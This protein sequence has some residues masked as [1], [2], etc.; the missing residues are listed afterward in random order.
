MLKI[1]IWNF[2]D[3]EA[4]LWLYLSSDLSV[5]LFSEL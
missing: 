4:L 5:M 3:F 2:K 1:V